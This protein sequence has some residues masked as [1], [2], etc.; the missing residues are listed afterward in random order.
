MVIIT[1]S[2]TGIKVECSDIGMMERWGLPVYSKEKLWQPYFI[3]T[4]VFRN[5]GMPVYA[6]T[7]SWLVV[8]WGQNVFGE[9][10]GTYYGTW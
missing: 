5:S 6:H 7:V 3:E 10:P 8:I 4:K 1:F 2:Q 9:L